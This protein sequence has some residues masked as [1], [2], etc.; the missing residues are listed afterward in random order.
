V[1][2]AAHPDPA[3]PEQRVAPGGIGLLDTHT[4]EYIHD[5]WLA[6]VCGDDLDLAGFIVAS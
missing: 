3:N 6:D 2:P 1:C 5:G 4:F